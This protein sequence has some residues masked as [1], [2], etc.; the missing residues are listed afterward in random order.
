MSRAITSKASYFFLF[1]LDNPNNNEYDLLAGTTLQQKPPPLGNP[2]SMSHYNERPPAGYFC[3]PHILSSDKSVAITQQQHQQQQQQQF[4]TAAMPEDGT[5][6]VGLLRQQAFPQQL[7]PA[8]PTS[9]LPP[10]GRYDGVTSAVANSLQPIFDW[11]DQNHGSTW[12]D[13]Y[14]DLEPRPFLEATT[15][16]VY[17]GS[18]SSDTQNGL[19]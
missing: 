4:C 18:F 15:S 14:Y 13:P 12:G 6:K 16:I 19:Q 11:F 10:L 8:A 1:G 9:R 17:D 2:G 5:T 7:Q 3:P